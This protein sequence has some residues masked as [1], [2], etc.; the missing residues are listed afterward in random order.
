MTTARWQRTT[1][2]S[3]DGVH[4]NYCSARSDR[5]EN[6]ASAGVLWPQSPQVVRQY[7]L[8]YTPVMKTAISLPDS[9]FHAADTFA[10]RAGMS[11]SEL[12]RKAVSDYME[13][14]RHDHVK[15]TLDAIYADEPSH[16]D[17]TLMKMQVMSLPEEDW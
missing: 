2:R 6:M 11:R 17:E 9:L 15:E 12:F 13:L 16:I 5:P 4:F 14:H 3:T 1:P 7:N 10:S 8:R